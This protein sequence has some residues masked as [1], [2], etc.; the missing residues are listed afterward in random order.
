VFP[1]AVPSRTTTPTGQWPMLIFVKVIAWRRP[2]ISAGCLC[3]AHAAQVTAQCS[4]H[5]KASEVK[6]T[7]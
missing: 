4:L 1:K 5:R 2:P 3:W 6:G 7:S